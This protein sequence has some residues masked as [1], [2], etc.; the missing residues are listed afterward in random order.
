MAGKQTQGTP[1]KKT[2]PKPK[3]E[4]ITITIKEYNTLKDTGKCA[5]KEIQGLRSTIS[6]AI[7][8]TEKQTKLTKQAQART[9]SVVSAL[10]KA[11]HDLK[12][13][14]IDNVVDKNIVL[15]REVAAAS[16]RA[17]TLG[18]DLKNRDSK[19]EE[20][21]REVSSAK[22]SLESERIAIESTMQTMQRSRDKAQE[23]KRTAEKVLGASKKETEK[24]NDR[25]QMLEGELSALRLEKQKKTPTPAGSR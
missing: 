8:E 15:R 13:N 11:E 4:K 12:K 7:A 10:Q 16:K 19:I 24:A 14:N 20:L 21:R 25:I 5:D 3:V 18:K 6:N 9:S 22:D 2:P 17:S 23:E 1:K